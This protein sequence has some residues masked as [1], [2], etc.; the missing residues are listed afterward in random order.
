VTGASDLSEVACDVGFFD[1]AHMTRMFRR[2]VG[3]TPTHL[4]AGLRQP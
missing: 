2:L 1:H 3:E 4:R